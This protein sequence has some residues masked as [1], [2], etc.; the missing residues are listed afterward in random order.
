MT[1]VMGIDPC[2]NQNFAVFNATTQKHN[3]VD[4]RTGLFEVYVPLP[5]VKG[6]N[7]NGPVVDLSLF[8]TPVCNNR[9]GLGD[10]W[11]F[12]FTTYDETH[13]QLTLHT[14]EVLKV[15]K[16]EELK[17]L[18]VIAR[19]QEE[20]TVLEVT[21]RDG[22][23]EVLRQQLTSNIYVPHTLTTDGL[24]VASMTWNCLEHDIEGVIHYQILLTEIND[25]VRKLFKVDY[26]LEGGS[27][28]I[29]LTFWPDDPVETIAYT[30]TVT[31]YTLASA[32]SPE[33]WQCSF[34]YITHSECGEL[35]VGIKSFTDVMEEVVYAANG[36]KFAEGTKLNAL[37]SVSTHTLTCPGREKLQRTFFYTTEG[38]DSKTVISEGGRDVVYVYGKDNELKSEA[39]CRAGALRKKEYTQQGAKRMIITTYEDEGGS[40]QEE[41][42]TRFEGE[43]IKENVQPG[44]RK[45]YTYYSRY[46]EDEPNKNLSAARLI[47]KIERKSFNSPEGVPVDDFPMKYVESEADYKY[48]GQL[49]ASA[50]LFEYEWLSGINTAKI[51][52]V[53]KIFNTTEWIGRAA[54]VTQRIAYYDEGFQK[55]RQRYISQFGNRDPDNAV[56]DRQNWYFTYTLDGTALT[57]TTVRR[58]AGD[59]ERSTAQTISVLSGRLISQV[60]EEGNQATFEYDAFGRLIAHTKCA[61]S[62]TYKQTTYYAYPSAR[63]L[64]ITEPNGRRLLTEQDGLDNLISESEWEPNKTPVRGAPGQWREI[65]RVYHDE[66]GRQ[67]YVGRFDKVGRGKIEDGCRILYDKWDEE[68]CRIYNE[69]RWVYNEYDPVRLTRSERTGYEATLHP[70]VVTTYDPSGEVIQVA[71]CDENGTAYKT[72]TFSYRI[73]G[74]LARQSTVGI[75]GTHFIDY[76]YDD[77]GRVVEERHIA[78]DTDHTQLNYCY[79]YSYPGNWLIT[80]AETVEIEVDQQRRTLGRRT[81]DGWG[82]V[83]SLTRGDVTETFAYTGANLEPSSKTN[84]DGSTLNYEYVS[85]LGKRLSKVSLNSD[86]RVCKQFKY[87]TARAASSTVSEG[88]CFLEC[89]Y[90]LHDQLIR[91]SANADGA[92]GKTTT[93]G[94]SQY[95]RLLSDCDV[96]GKASEYSYDSNHGYRSKTVSDGITTMTRVHNFGNLRLE[97][98]SSPGLKFE[99]SVRIKYEYCAYDRESY[100]NFTLPDQRELR[101]WR[102]YHPDGRLRK[103]VLLVSGDQVGSREFSYTVS[104]RLALCKT[105]GVWRP[106]T[107]ANKAID[108]Q[109]FTYDAMGNVTTCIT[110]FG[111][112]RCVSTYTYDAVSGSRLIKVEHDHPDY[113]SSQTLS[114][115]S[116]GR[117]T[118]DQTGKKYHYDW[119]GRLIQAGSIHYTYNPMDQLLTRSEEGGS[120]QIVYDGMQVRGEYDLKEDS[121]RYL[122]AG[123]AACKVQT[124]RISGVDRVLL[125]LCDTA[126]SVIATYDCAAGTLKHHA[127]SAYGQHFSDEKE[128]LLGFN[129]EYLDAENGQYPLGQGYRWYAPDSMQFH[130]QDSMSPFGEGG[131]HAYR[132]CAGDPINVSDPS[133]HIG[134]GKVNRRLRE[135]WGDHLPG[136]L[137]LGEQ[138]ALISSIIWSGLGVLTAIISGGTSLLFAAVLVGLAIIAAATAITAVVIADSNPELAAILGWISLAASLAG[139]LVTILRKVGQLAIQLA[140]S[141]RLLASKVVHKV[142]AGL[143]RSNK[144]WAP[145][146]AYRAPRMADFR[147]A[148]Q[149]AEA[150]APVDTREFAFFHFETQQVK[151]QSTI[152]KLMTATSGMFDAGDTNTVVC[153]VTGVLAGGGYFDSE[154]EQFING[155][156][157]NATWLPWGHFNVGRYL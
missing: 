100:R 5:S 83:T 146:K 81:F 91:R 157:N 82:R 110:E 1:N 124:V 43:G 145:S 77:G 66:L 99:G 121:A 29:V 117:I 4:P 46:R 134:S 31:D 75:A 15:K 18:S 37:P 89:Q 85:E 88:A 137:G 6:N 11:S 131:R 30:L 107:P 129:G 14:G 28:N 112:E 13:E 53:T 118:Q 34:N 150:L 119:L 49:M 38:D 27:G 24:N 144:G 62:E 94:F 17:T 68:C 54:V 22:R 40:R 33:Q 109:S 50:T 39:Y 41:V 60:D 70:S 127:Y 23:V 155:N 130:T 104:G 138:G 87:A 132:Y 48:G 20:N 125:Q 2:D 47:E 135:T 32:A 73:T 21:R 101:V 45:S 108:S 8:Y 154:R 128:S 95:G 12:A 3:W 90:D 59:F 56:A 133:G 126:G 98:V 115:D 141:G 140:R 86:P 36:Y 84:A 97:E 136:P 113:P 152:A 116:S 44:S 103:D 67:V 72:Q 96:E 9:A 102:M 10:G 139:G 35:L 142:G 93:Y 74:Q 151:Q 65:Q 16:G 153:A 149:V 114:Y 79:F 147:T 76:S 106:A 78:T 64:H 123:S 61:Q 7:G 122:H 69:E 105:E 42:V 80:D 26:V 52:S 55:G 63:T 71:L 156:I 148:E 25:A 92:N 143:A 58:G 111:E 120:K 57:T 19:W 51:A